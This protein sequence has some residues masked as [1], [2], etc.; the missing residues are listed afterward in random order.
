MRVRRFRAVIGLISAPAII[1]GGLAA[2]ALASAGPAAAAGQPVTQALTPPPP[3]FETC[4]M[5]GN[6]F[7]CAGARTESYGPDDTG[8]AC[9]SGAGAFDIFDQGTHNQHAIRYYNAAGDLTR[10]VIYDQY[11]SQLSNLLTAA[12]VPYTQHNTITD[13]L[14]VPGDFAS[15]T[16]TITGEVNFTVPHM[17]AVFLN[18]GRTVFGADGALEFSAGP[19][20]FIDYFNDGNTAATAELCAALG[21]N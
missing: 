21:A 9:G 3:S 6:G 13:D 17:G 5:V 16:E 7:I 11:F 1:A 18:A 15:A 20:G 12:A 10:R 19:Q 4:K 2:L 8:I 14:A